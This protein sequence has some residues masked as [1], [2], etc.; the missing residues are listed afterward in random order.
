MERW[1]LSNE[2]F[3]SSNPVQVHHSLSC[4]WLPREL[5]QRKR[6]STHHPTPSVP[7]IVYTAI[8][9]NDKMTARLDRPN[10]PSAPFA[11]QKKIAA[12][13]KSPASAPYISTRRTENINN[14]TLTRAPPRQKENNPKPSLIHCVCPD[15]P[16][17]AR[18]LYR[19][20][21]SC[22][23]CRLDFAPPSLLLLGHYPPFSSRQHLSTLNF[24]DPAR[25]QTPGP[26]VRT[27]R[28]RGKWGGDSLRFASLLSP[29]I[30]CVCDCISKTRPMMGRVLDPW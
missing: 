1:N 9:Q 3:E 10:L 16:P 29:K 8:S 22:V 12:H 24:K 19:T 18:Y 7:D 13:T 6:Q 15:P 17:S 4:R 28:D 20:S 30:R 14:E 2:N 5:L 26:P 21:S 11:Q 23:P 27:G 25:V